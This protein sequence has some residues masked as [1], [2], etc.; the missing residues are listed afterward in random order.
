MHIN[1]FGKYYDKNGFVYY[2]LDNHI[3]RFYLKINYLKK[4]YKSKINDT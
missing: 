2:D 4:L 1:P 3:Y